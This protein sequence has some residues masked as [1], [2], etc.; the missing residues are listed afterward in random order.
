MDTKENL[1]NY[2]FN[3]ISN[4]TSGNTYFHMTVGNLMKAR[5]LLFETT[6]GYKMDDLLTSYIKALITSS[7]HQHKDHEME[8]I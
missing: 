5:R 6:L 8:I 4:W 2:P 7:S 3:V 1:A